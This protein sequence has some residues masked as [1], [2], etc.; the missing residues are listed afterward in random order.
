M[1][2]IVNLIDMM[3]T[4]LTDVNTTP[5]DQYVVEIATCL[6]I[7]TPFTKNKVQEHGAF[8]CMSSDGGYYDGI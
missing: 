7:H 5:I 1:W 3:I 8:W 4:H 2:R 6:Y